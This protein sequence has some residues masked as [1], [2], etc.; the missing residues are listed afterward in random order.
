MS[1]VPGWLGRI[2]AGLTEISERYNERRA[3][4]ERE[5]DDSDSPMLADDHV[6]PP[7]DYAPD[8]AARP[9]PALAVPWGVRVAAEAGWRLLILAGTLWV[10]MRIISAVQLVVLSF[11]IALLITAILQPTVARL[12]RHGVPRGPATAL[13]AMFGFIVIGLIGWF[14]GLMVWR[15]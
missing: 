1:R 4:A 3:E 8:V 14:V 10:L 9:D 2:G 6:P 13:T 11:V 5:R 15:P 7:P 12:R